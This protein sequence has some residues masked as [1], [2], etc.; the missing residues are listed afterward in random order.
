MASIELDARELTALADDLSHLPAAAL[1]KVRPVLQKGALKIKNQLQSE[2]SG[3]RHFG[4]IAPTVS[5]DT[6]ETPSAIEAEIGPDRGR[7]G[8]AGLAGAYFGWSRGGA[9]LPDPVLA[10]EAEAPLV[11]RFLSGLLEDSL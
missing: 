2:A 11:E 3:S 9:S 7:G 4:K 10:L 6:T 8:A 5:Y 1:A